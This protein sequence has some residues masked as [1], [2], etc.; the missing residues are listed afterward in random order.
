MNP[1]TADLLEAI[2]SLG[3]DEAVLLPNNGNVVMAAEQAARVAGRPVRVVPTTSIPAGLAALVAFN[4][5]RSA[6]ENAEAMREAAQQ[7]ASGEV[8]VASRDSSVD[9]V[10][11][12]KGDYLALLEGDAVAA[13]PS[14]DEVTR[15][16]LERMLAEP[17]EL[18]TVIAGEGAP[19][20]NGVLDGLASTRPEL[21]VD[22]HEG[23][24][25]NYPLLIS[26]E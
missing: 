2:E 18:L 14:F 20:L 16:L 13:G 7:V 4:G 23:G 24:Q 11:V 19:P 26:A 15:A 10:A 9:G 5:E 6:E 22:L 17:R 12:R 21:E 8:A 25:P 1:S 3:A